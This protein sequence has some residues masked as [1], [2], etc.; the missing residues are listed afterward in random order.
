M[1]RSKVFV[2]YSHKDRKALEQLQRF[3]KPLE[4]DG[5]VDCW[6]DTRIEPG[7]DWHAEIDAALDTATAAVVFVSQDFLASDF[8]YRKELPL[9]LRRA[10]ADELTL[11][12]VFLSPSTV[13]EVEFPF[14][15]A[16]SG[17][18]RRVKL[19]KYQGVG[20]PQRPLSIRSWP[21]RERIYG[22]L[23]RRLKALGSGP[24]AAAERPRA[25][26][27][28]VFHTPPAELAVPAHEVELTV[29]LERRGAVLQARY[30][31]PGREPFASATA[32]WEEHREEVEAIAAVLYGGGDAVGDL[33]AHAPE[34]KGCGA[35]LFRL[36]FG[37]ERRWKPLL[38]TLFHRPEPQPQPHPVF[39]PVR[40]RIATAESLL[41]GLPWRLT[42]WRGRLLADDRWL[43][44]T[45]GSVDPMAVESTTAPSNVLIVAPR[46]RSG[47]PQVTGEA[48]DRGHPEA[49]TDLLRDVWTAGR[50][51]KLR[52]VRTVRTRRQLESSLRGMRPHVV[53]FYGHG[54]L[55][56]G[57]PALLFGDGALPLT[58]LADLFA[59]VGNRPAVVFLNATGLGG[60]A[61]PTPGELLGGAVPL[62]L[63]R[64]LPRWTADST[65]VALAWFRRWLAG[66]EDPVAALHALRR[67]A[68]DPGP[69]TATLAVHAAYKGWKTA[70]LRVVARQRLPNL[71]LDRDH[72]KALVRKHLAELSRSDSR[73]VMAL[74]AYGERGNSLGSLWS[75]LRDY[76]ELE[77]S[78]RAEI[79]WPRLEFPD[80]RGDL[81]R[82]LEHELRLQLDAEAD[83]PLPHLLRRHAPNVAGS[84]KRSVL[85]LNWGT[86]GKGSDHQTRLKP[87]HLSAWLRFSSEILGTYCPDD[88]RIVS[89]LAIEAEASKHRRLARD[90]KE[91]RRQP[92]CKRAEFRLSVLPALGEVP[93]EDLL[94]FLE[95]PA[96]S[97]CD[98]GI[99]DEMAERLIAETGGDFERTVALMEEAEKG[100]WYDLLARLRREQGAEASELSDEEY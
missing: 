41:L 92:W 73:R 36:L 79:D 82:D 70:A 28:A 61:A 62:V 14:P 44:M 22:K 53:Y 1:A 20:T 69:E 26:S 13:D 88:L 71:R 87:R 23:T 4:R 81:V 37:G 65:S 80:V 97:S 96:N 33:I 67:K 6:D 38:R 25:G 77:L 42:A 45:S 60:E 5:L 21:D 15:D 76:L 46:G 24:E 9:L 30:H 56:G 58:A 17:Q 68:A 27:G 7:D 49:L 29:E 59:E 19:T 100:S 66:A 48:P 95:D 99:Q 94:D 55:R 98:P 11:I 10:E 57:R 16:H 43:F 34:D 86:F 47:A 84:D 54:G 18:E 50:E 2:S 3:L 89:Y 74:V 64:R 8:I 63:W 72:Q 51:E 91:E 85:W 83:E 35:S 32:P 75:Q 52:F 40:L 39:A 31:L 93:E 12:P 90:L 78:N